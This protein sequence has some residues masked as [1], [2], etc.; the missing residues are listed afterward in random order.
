ME[1]LGKKEHWKK[2]KYTIIN[3]RYYM[4]VFNKLTTIFHGLLSY[5]PQK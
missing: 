1:N 2:G 3:Y 4:H 5:S